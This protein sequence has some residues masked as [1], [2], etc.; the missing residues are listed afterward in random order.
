MNR[1]PGCDYIIMN[2]TKGSI[3]IPSG[4]FGTSLCVT[5]WCY[6]ASTFFSTLV[7]V[8]ACRLIGNKPLPKLIRIHDFTFSNKII[9]IKFPFKMIHMKISSPKWRSCREILTIYTGL[10]K[11]NRSLNVSVNHKQGNTLADLKFPRRISHVI[12]VL[13]TEFQIRAMSHIATMRMWT[14]ALFA[15]QISPF[16]P[17]PRNLTGCVIYVRHVSSI[18]CFIINIFNTSFDTKNCIRSLKIT[19][20]YIWQCYKPSPNRPGLGKDEEP[21]EWSWCF[22]SRQQKTGNNKYNTMSN[23]G[24]SMTAYVH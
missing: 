20:I 21:R 11:S 12:N 5:Q 10:I 22:Y 9:W 7:H 13:F 15:V 14:N 16:V 4:L 8:I 2:V 17:E 6:M 18:T 24:I 3:P 23:P 19:I 1:G